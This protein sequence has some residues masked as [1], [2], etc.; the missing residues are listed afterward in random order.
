MVRVEEKNTVCRK[1]E[2][3]LKVIY[4]IGNKVMLQDQFFRF[5]KHFKIMDTDYK[6][7][8]MLKDLEQAELIKK[9]Q[10]LN[11]K[12]QVIILKK[13][14]IR[15]LENKNSSQEVASVPRKSTDRSLISVVKTEMILELFQEQKLSIEQIEQILKKYKSSILCNKNQ[16]LYY[17]ENILSNGKVNKSNLIYKRTQ[18]QAIIRAEN[19]KKGSKEI[20]GKGTTGKEYSSGV[21]LEEHLNINSLTGETK[22]EKDLKKINMD[23][24]INAN[25]YIKTIS[26]K[27]NI[28]HINISIV[29]IHNTQ[30]A[31]E[32]LWKILKICYVIKFLF[33]QNFKI[34]IT[35]ELLNKSAVDMVNKLYNTKNNEEEYKYCKLKDFRLDTANRESILMNLGIN[36][37][38]LK[39]KVKQSK[40]SRYYPN[41]E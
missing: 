2:E 4:K 31:D 41:L 33:V 13:Y 6:I 24:L 12:Y 22:I 25:A 37:R 15:F 29:D 23:T 21:N 1:Y 35:L 19:R 26:V 32:F 16:G 20:E 36:E 7:N 34:N 39:I 40:L 18:K 8:K 28:Q 11:T 27:D 9:E 17:I 3:Q 30:N 10:F 5:L 14:P 38:N